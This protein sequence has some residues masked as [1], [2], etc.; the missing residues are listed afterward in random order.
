MRSCRENQARDTNEKSGQTPIIDNN[1]QMIVTLTASMKSTREK[2]Q[3]PKTIYETII[4]SITVAKTSTKQ[5]KKNECGI[6]RRTMI[7]NVYL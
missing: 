5:K 2:V 6:H 4:S 1:L 7:I 3:T